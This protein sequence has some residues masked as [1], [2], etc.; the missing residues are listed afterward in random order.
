VIGTTKARRLVPEGFEFGH[1]EVGPGGVTIH[2]GRRED[3][4]AECPCCG[5]GC[6]WVHS[7]YSWTLADLPWHGVAVRM[8]L[9][10]R[11]MFCE[12]SFPDPQPLLV[13]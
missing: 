10:S 11:R 6:S 13:D 12:N 2:G 5:S 9:R 1:V 7:R 8:R 3:A 4:P